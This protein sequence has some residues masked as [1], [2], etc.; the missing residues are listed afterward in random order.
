LYWPRACWAVSWPSGVR[1]RAGATCPHPPAL[2]PPTHTV[3][4]VVRVTAPPIFAAIGFRLW[5]PYTYEATVQTLEA[6]TG[7][8]RPSADVA[9]DALARGTQQAGAAARSYY[10]RMRDKQ[11]RRQH[12]E[13]PIDDDAP[14]AAVVAVPVSAPVTDDPAAPVAPAAPAAPAAV[15][16]AAVAPAPPAP[17]REPAEAAAVAAPEEVVFVA[18]QATQE[19]APAAETDADAELLRMYT[20]RSVKLGLPPPS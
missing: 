7:W 10:Q 20:T 3:N 13:P 9:V 12:E 19:P 5:Y 2:T 16:P 4:P 15:T 14:A 18:P 1:A 8:E 11:A 6:A 17:A